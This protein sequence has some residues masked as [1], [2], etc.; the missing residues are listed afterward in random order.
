MQ[1]YGE[2]SLVW[3]A[4]V[5]YESLSFIHSQDG[6]LIRAAALSVP[7]ILTQ[8]NNRESPRQLCTAWQEDHIPASTHT[9]SWSSLSSLLSG[10][11]ETESVS[12]NKHMIVSDLL[13]KFELKLIYYIYKTR[14]LRLAN[15][16]MC[17]HMCMSACMYVYTH[18][19]A[20]L[21]SVHVCHLY[22][23]RKCSLFFYHKDNRETKLQSVLQLI[24]G[25]NL[26]NMVQHM[27]A[28]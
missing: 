18:T 13:S 28:I 12:D 17:L 15:V 1:C 11:A 16:F 27:H 21:C 6:C 26:I 9:R 24:T 25:V 8:K 14:I 3:T 19:C 20:C 7:Q 23:Y 22:T 4:W 10:L 5:K 2:I